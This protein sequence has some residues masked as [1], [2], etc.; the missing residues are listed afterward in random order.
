MTEHKHCCEHE[1]THVH[2]H[3]DGCTCCSCVEAENIFEECAAEEADERAEFR[4]E[5]MFLGAAGAV[6]AICL[7]AENYLGESVYFRAVFLLLYILC[8]LPVLKIACR[9]LLKG[10]IFNEFTLMGGASLA[11]IAIGE[12]SESVGVMIFYRLGEAFQERASSQSRRSIKALLAQKP[13]S[14]RLI[15]DGKTVDI[16]PKEIVKGDLVKVMPGEIIPIDGTVVSGVSQI[17]CSPITGE[18]IPVPASPGSEVHGGTLSLDGL[19]TV[20]AV[21]PFEDSTIARMLEMVQNAVARKAPTERFITRFAKLYTPTVFALAAAIAVIP[22]LLGY[23]AFREWFYR[24]LVMLVI[25]CPCALVISIPLGYFGGIGGASKKGILVKGANVFDAVGNVVMAVFDKT[26]TLTYGKF[27]VQKVV[28]ESGIDER[29]L[30]KTA[31]YAETGSSHPLSKAI[32]TA[33]GAAELPP[34]AE[35]TQVPGKGMIMKC[36]DDFIASG[37]AAL[38]AD[39]GVTAPEITE[40]GTVDHVM[41]NGKYLGYI[42]VADSIRADAREA[43]DELRGI[44][45]KAIYMLTGDRDEVASKTAKEL[46]L[47]GYRSE[48]LPGDKV[49]ALNEL[50]GGDTKKTIYIG[51]G[52]NDGPV[53]VTSE[54]GIAMGGFGSQVAVEVADAVILDDSP[55]KVA[56][57]LRIAKKTRAIVWENVGL[58]L[59]VKG[60]F[61]IFGAVGLAGLWEAIFAD[62]GVALLAILNATRA[63]RV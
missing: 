8:G 19:L 14:A 10:D 39:Y 38:L 23:G 58:A 48:L 46:G 62:V 12:V 30:L 47:D 26:G 28:P 17:D 45:I 29:E 55:V 22:P 5:I 60:I 54:T 4:H 56:E 9:A 51:D 32:L 40:P 36:G 24:G 43:I 20:E 1:H 59:G 52:V 41:K 33:A 2:G 50:C 37:N 6:F 11:A 44:G 31:A 3:D 16:D 7:V 42:L 35:V 13:M 63:S 61:L 25:S 53:L 57:L 18:S 34:S 27:K 21:G 15:K 49:D